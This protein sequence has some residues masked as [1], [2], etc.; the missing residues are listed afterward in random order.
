[1]SKSK[2]LR[3]SIHGYIEIDDDIT[4]LIIDTKYFKD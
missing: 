1:M 4:S 3:D 2:I